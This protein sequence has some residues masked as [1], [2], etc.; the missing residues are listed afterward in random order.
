MKI[1]PETKYKI[2]KYLLSKYTIVLVVSFVLLTFFDKHNLIS[3]FRTLNENRKMRKEINFYEQEIDDNQKKMRD[4]RSGKESLEKYAREKYYLK[5][6]SEDIFIIK[7]D[8]DLP[9]R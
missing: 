3:R 5:R 8:D 9:K 1:S 4:M 2:K 7:E 6:D